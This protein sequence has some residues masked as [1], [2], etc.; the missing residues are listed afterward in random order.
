V[1][2]SFGTLI[3]MFDEDNGRFCFQTAHGIIIEL[4]RIFQT[5]FRLALATEHLQGGPPPLVI[6][7]NPIKTHSVVDF[8]ML[9]APPKTACFSAKP[10]RFYMLN[11]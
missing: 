11:V 9:Q 1:N 6:P 4:I 7:I 10:R 8:M 5:V 2:G 3:L